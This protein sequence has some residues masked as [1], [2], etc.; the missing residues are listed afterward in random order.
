MTSET[1]PTMLVS[2]SPKTFQALFD[3]LILSHVLPSEG[4]NPQEACKSPHAWISPPNVL[5]QAQTL[6]A[7]LEGST[8]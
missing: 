2:G 1:D 5:I 3:L 7:L 4:P 8:K 6:H